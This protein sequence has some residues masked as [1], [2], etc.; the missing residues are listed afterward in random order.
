MGVEEPSAETWK[1]WLVELCIAACWAA[2]AFNSGRTPTGGRPNL[3]RSSDTLQAMDSG[4]VRKAQ[5][6]STKKNSEV[7]ADNVERVKIIVR[8]GISRLV[9]V[10]EISRWFT[11]STVGGER[12][13]LFIAWAG[14]DASHVRDMMHRTMVPSADL[15]IVD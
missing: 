2:A 1:T 6:G 9:W 3:E 12:R 14:N 15:Q 7:M 8:R 10:G 11:V 4:D 5:V 13:T